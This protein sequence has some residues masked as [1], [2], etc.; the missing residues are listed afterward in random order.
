MSK[1]RNRK[2]FSLV[3]MIIS[4]AILAIMS[5]YLLKL[6]GAAQRINEEAFELDGATNSL[7]SQLTILGNKR[8]HLSDFAEFVGEDERGNAVYSFQNFLDE[9]F[10]V[11]EKADGIYTLGVD[12]RKEASMPKGEGLY[13]VHARIKHLHPNNET[14]LLAELKT[15]M[16]FIDGGGEQ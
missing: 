7:K 3:E 10:L 6:F 13:S 2:G 14:E 12:F 5:I 8:E 9:S 1:C 16:L 15:Y 11:V 4:V